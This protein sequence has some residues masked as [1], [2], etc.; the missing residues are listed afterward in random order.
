MLA[1]CLNRSD[2]TKPLRDFKNRS[3]IMKTAQIFKS[4]K[5]LPIPDTQGYEIDEY[6][7]VYRN[8]KRLKLQRKAGKWFA[9]LYT[10]D[11]KRVSFDSERLARTL[12]GEDE[13]ILR[14]KDIEQNYDVR[15]VPEFPRYVVTSYGAVYC[16]D[17]PKRGRNA[18]TCYLVS[19]AI[20]RNKPYVTLYKAD[21]TC[22]KKQVAWVVKSAW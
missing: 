8:D 18:G 15:T 4:E 10:V 12:F 3:E 2:I 22:R 5:R 6:G 21:G 1:F 11:G 19:E 13:Y 9:Q 16:I 7:F 20:S 14:R 17:P